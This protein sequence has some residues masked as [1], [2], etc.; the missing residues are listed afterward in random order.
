MGVLEGRFRSMGIIGEGWRTPLGMTARR[1]EVDI[2]GLHV[3]YGVL[4]MQRKVAIKGS[5]PKG[6]TTITL[7]ARDLG[8]FTQHPLFLRAAA[9]AVQG[10]AFAF[11]PDSVS[12]VHHPSGGGEVRFEGVWAADGERYRVLMQPGGHRHHAAAAT[13]TTGDG[14]AAP[15]KLRVGAQ[16]VPRG[17]GAPDAAAAG[18]V[19]AGIADFFTNMALDL[20]GIEVT[21][22]V[23]SLRPWRGGSAAA[24]GGYRGSSSS[25]KAGV[26]N[27]G[28]VLDICMRVRI[29]SFPPLNMQF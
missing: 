4:V 14:A 11:D 21:R 16:H 27:E 8:A 26:V 1:L 12:I 25:D 23:L 10:H 13:A 19:A 17:G 22:P 18:R 5:P 24:G 6:H 15:K 9:T 2:S 3:D 28:D 7:N 20:D 29:R